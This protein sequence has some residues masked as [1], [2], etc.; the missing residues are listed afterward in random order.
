VVVSSEDVTKVDGVVV[1]VSEPEP[2]PPVA[3]APAAIPAASA[4]RAE[5]GKTLRKLTSPVATRR[6]D[7]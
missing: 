5:F 1:V 4:N 6:D 2:P 3:S 7:S